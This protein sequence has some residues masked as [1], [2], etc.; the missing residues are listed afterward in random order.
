M[1]VVG[2]NSAEFRKG[3]TP[4]PGDQTNQA[5]IEEHGME[6]SKELEFPPVCV[7][8]MCM[9]LLCVACVWPEWM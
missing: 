9:C 8:C 3:I 1:L 2:S 4:N 5:T 6:Q 7:L